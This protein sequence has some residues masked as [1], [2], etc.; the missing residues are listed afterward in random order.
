M[1]KE[2]DLETARKRVNDLVY[3]SDHPPS[4]PK[5]EFL[6]S[7]EELLASYAVDEVDYNDTESAMIF[8]LKDGKFAVATEWGD[9]TGHG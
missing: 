8:K 5:S 2:F 6:A 7:L 1:K 3:C 4:I 9:T